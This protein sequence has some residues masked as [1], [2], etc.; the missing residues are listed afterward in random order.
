MIL[1]HNFKWNLYMHYYCVLLSFVKT[2]ITWGTTQKTEKTRKQQNCCT[3]MQKEKKK[4]STNCKWSEYY[5]DLLSTTCKYLG[6]CYSRGLCQVL[7]SHTFIIIYIVL[8]INHPIKNIPCGVSSE[9]SNL[10]SKIKCD[11]HNKLLGII[12]GSNPAPFDM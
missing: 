10:S 3:K 1:K 5:F 9:V 6:G 4:Y 2:A 12:W 11:K 8:I 7:T